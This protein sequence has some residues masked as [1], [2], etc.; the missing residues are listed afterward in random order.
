[1][2]IEV[3]VADEQTDKPVDTMRWVRLATEV[4]KAEGVRD[5]CELSM[6]FVDEEVMAGLNKQFHGKDGPTD[7]LAF[8]I[9]DDV[10]E[11]GRLPDSLGP[12]GPSDDFE[13]SDLPTL[14]GDVVVCPAVARRNA[15]DHAG[16]YEDEMALLVVHGILHLLGMDHVDD[17]EAKEMEQRERELLARFHRT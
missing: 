7:V 14:L 8:P 1:M 3:F 15:P 9:D 2:G 4:I 12:A 5:E 17:G 10:Y 6:L 11:G 13:P 16:T